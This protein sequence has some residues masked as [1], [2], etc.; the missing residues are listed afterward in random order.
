MGPAGSLPGRSKAEPTPQPAHVRSVVEVTVCFLA[1]DDSDSAPQCNCQTRARQRNGSFRQANKIAECRTEDR[2]GGPSN[3]PRVLV[4]SDLGHG[5]SQGTPRCALKKVALVA[6]SR[7]KDTISAR[8]GNIRFD[9]GILIPASLAQ[10]RYSAA[11]ASRLVFRQAMR[12]VS[13]FAPG[14]AFRRP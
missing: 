2:A 8:R 9:I 3:S 5:P 6:L 7:F 11:W 14:R 12:S 1:P 13:R 10:D 4:S